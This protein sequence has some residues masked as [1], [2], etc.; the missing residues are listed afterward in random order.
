[1]DVRNYL[2]QLIMETPKLSSAF[3]RDTLNSPLG[4][5]LNQMEVIEEILVAPGDIG[6]MRKHYEEYIHIKNWRIAQ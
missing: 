6:E 3:N 4:I 2:T 5:E 1:M